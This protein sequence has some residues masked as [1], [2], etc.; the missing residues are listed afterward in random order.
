MTA[1][2]SATTANVGQTA[3]NIWPYNMR[4]YSF[5]IVS[6]FTQ[7]GESS[8]QKESPCRRRWQTAHG[9][10]SWRLLR[11]QQGIILHTSKNTIHHCH[12]DCPLPWPGVFSNPM[13]VWWQ[14]KILG[15][16]C[17]AVH[18]QRFCFW[19]CSFKFLE[20]ECFVL[21][22]RLAWRYHIEADRWAIWTATVNHKTTAPLCNSVFEHWFPGLQ[23]HQGSV[24]L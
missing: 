18:Y 15:K 19:S 7:N 22:F 23:Y 16:R 12:S 2:N 17:Q 11:K 13:A 5:R 1:E 3:N 24:C 9:C 21:C 8:R 6:S 10:Y 4:L 14:W 20:S